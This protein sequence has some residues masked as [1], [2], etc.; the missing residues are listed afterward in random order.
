MVIIMQIINKYCPFC[1][2]EHDLEK[3]IKKH[4]CLIKN[5]KVE[6]MME[7]FYCN[8]TEEEFWT[9]EM[10]DKNLKNARIAYRNKINI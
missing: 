5:E 10:L 6:Y 9:G 4:L 1:E 2:I 8:I 3:R 7:S